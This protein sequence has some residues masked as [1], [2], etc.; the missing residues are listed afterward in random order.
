MGIGFVIFASQLKRRSRAHLLRHDRISS[1]GFAFRFGQFWTGVLYA[2]DVFWSCKSYPGCATLTVFR[3]AANA[4]SNTFEQNCSDSTQ[5]HD[6]ADTILQILRNLLYLVDA[7]G[8]CGSATACAGL[9]PSSASPM[10]AWA[11][12]G[13]PHPGLWR[14]GLAAA[15]CALGGVSE[16]RYPAN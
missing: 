9:S 5:I 12:D 1:V 10:L 13:A 8:V 15:F 11:G 7:P 6:T 2:L 14:L 4:E 3:S 16:C